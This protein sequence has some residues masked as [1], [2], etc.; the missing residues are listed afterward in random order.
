M[1]PGFSS[2]AAGNRVADSRYVPAGTRT[3][4]APGPTRSTR[5]KSVESVVSTASIRKRAVESGVTI[6]PL[7]IAGALGS[8]ATILILSASIL[9]GVKRIGEG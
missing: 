7:R 4:Y 2:S 8:T 9:S 3:A 5:R 6:F 1:G